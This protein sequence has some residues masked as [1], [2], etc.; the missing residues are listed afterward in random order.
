LTLAAGAKGS[1]CTTG[2]SVAQIALPYTFK[3]VGIFVHKIL[4][5]AKIL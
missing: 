5:N 4:S 2:F 3:C 1:T